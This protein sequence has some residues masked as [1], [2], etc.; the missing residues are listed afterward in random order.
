MR[1]AILSPVPSR[2][3]KPPESGVAGYTASLL[4]YVRVPVT[5]L[6]QKDASGDAPG[7]AGIARIWEPNL[8]LPFQ[9]LAAVRR[10]A[11][12]LLHV[13]HEFNLYGGLVQG[14]F[15][16]A[17]LLWLRKRGL[18]V[19]TTVHGV[20]PFDAVTA[21][22][23][24]RNSLP[25][26]V[27]FVRRAFRLSYEAI[28]AASDLLVVHHDYFRHVLSEEYGIRP[29]K[30][31]VIPHG[32]QDPAGQV[33]VGPRR[34]GKNVLCLG[35]LTGYKLP[36]LVVDVAE[37]SALPDAVFTFCVGINPRIRT[38]RYR[39]R[40]GSLE[41]RVRAL[42]PRAVWKGYVPD[43]SLA[44]TV[45]SA[46]VIVLPY[47]ECVSVSG[48]SA[49]AR[50]WHVPLCYSRPLRPLFG[51]GSLEFEL[52]SKALSAAIVGALSGTASATDFTFVGW[53]D[54]ATA[55]TN[56]WMRLLSSG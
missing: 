47:T 22:F 6:A 45:Q 3:G 40:A 51:P 35:F 21:E 5:V 25:G 39:E 55:T 30:I 10:L 33:P 31:E 56:M 13:Q 18:K 44:I 49:L 14:M 2:P 24:L 16:T 50:Q 54:A 34:V 48:V 1:V 17:T 8:G 15:L 11:P 9:V 19:V 26:S 20:V 4:E 27:Y 23:L 12:D 36:E 7:V 29:E 42:G 52:N 43:E 53:R 32:S 28:A 38:R 41:T 37:S 46:D